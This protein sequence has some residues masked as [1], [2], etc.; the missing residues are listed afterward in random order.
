M[1]M[2]YFIAIG[3]VEMMK[4]HHSVAFLEKTI[5][6]L[7]LHRICL[8][9]LK[10]ATVFPLFIPLSAVCYFWWNLLCACNHAILYNVPPVLELIVTG[11]KIGEYEMRL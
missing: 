7:G 10:S 1:L 8:N 4:I 2:L 3:C 6:F 9:A 11:N 5:D